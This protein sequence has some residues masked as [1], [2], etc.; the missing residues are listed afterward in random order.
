MSRLFDCCVLATMGAMAEKNGRE[1]FQ[2]AS[3]L[4]ADM[5]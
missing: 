1:M 2:T 5:V 3:N 4:S